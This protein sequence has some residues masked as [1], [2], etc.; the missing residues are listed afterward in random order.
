ML[1]EPTRSWPGAREPFLAALDPPLFD[2]VI[3]AL[4]ALRGRVKLA[5]L[6]NNPYGADVLDRHGLHVDVFD[7][8]VV[9]DPAM[10]KPDPRAFTPLLDAL[11]LAPTEIPY[12]GDSVRG[13]RGRRARRRAAPGLDQPLGRSVAGPAGVPH[14]SLSELHRMLTVGFDLD[15]TLVDSRPGIRA[16]MAAL[17]QETGATIDIDVIVSRLGPKLEWEL[18]QWFPADQVAH[19]CKRYRAHYWE[20]CVG[21]RHALVAGRGRA[22]DAVRSRDGR[23]VIVTAKSESLAHR[24]LKTVGSKA[25]AVVGHVYG[26]EKRDA[27]MAHGAS[28]Y[29]GDT[30]TDVKSALDASATAVAVTTGPDDSPTLTAAGADVVLDSLEQFPEWLASTML[31]GS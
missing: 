26:D 9:A 7:C 25:D 1:H 14:R 18:A 30:V 15:M 24:C 16:S 28:I 6:T 11:E 21:D 2:D 31:V 29:V 8:V 20:H 19:A 17:A 10:R 3:P 23:V 22:V 4:E 5:L 13:R 12:V 27:L